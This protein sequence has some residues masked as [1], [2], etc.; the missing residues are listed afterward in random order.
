MSG[1]VERVGV[2]VEV[3]IYLDRVSQDLNS[4]YIFD[5]SG[6]FVVVSKSRI[7]LV[8][9][10]IESCTI[11]VC[12]KY[13]DDCRKIF[14]EVEMCLC[15]GKVSV[16]VCVASTPVVSWGSSFVGEHC[17]ALAG[18]EAHAEPLVAD[19]I[20]PNFVLLCCCNKFVRFQSCWL[21]ISQTKIA[22][23]S[24]LTSRSRR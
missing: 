20:E 24:P 6:A 2:R 14:V 7:F 19:P 5:C 16:S 11:S 12:E 3:G 17:D 4:V 22:F 13:L 1:K 23:R 21:L 15:V 9:G 18:R 8:C 10:E